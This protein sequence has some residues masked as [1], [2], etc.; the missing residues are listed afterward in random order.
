MDDF[1]LP[2]DIETPTFDIGL[3]DIDLDLDAFDLGFESNNIET[4]HIKPRLY[5]H[6]PTYAVKYDNAEKMADEV[7]AAI[8]AGERV[9][10]L[11]SGNFIFGDFI[12]AFAVTQALKMQRL[13][14]TTLSFGQENI[15]SL[16]NLMDLGFVEKLDIIVSDYFWSHNRQNIKYVYDALDHDDRFQLAVAGVHTKTILIEA[17]GKK[18]IISGSA[19]L[20]SSRSVEMFTAETNDDLY[21]FH[22]AWQEKILTAYGTVNK[23][24]RANALFDLI[25]G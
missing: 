23:A 18:I 3:G 2:D 14:I 17:R 5:R 22:I 8:L 24:I 19:N 9:D 10:A 12:E 20:R 4:R 1:T 15:D 13:T 25:K 16:K 7:G 11:V 6:V 21:D